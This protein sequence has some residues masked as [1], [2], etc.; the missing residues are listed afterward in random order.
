MTHHR[1]PSLRSSVG[2]ADGDDITLLDK[3]LA[4]N[5]RSQHIALPAYS[6]DDD[7][8]RVFLK[9]HLDGLL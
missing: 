4:K 3:H 5:L 2:F 8:P 1:T 9:G 6:S 7:V